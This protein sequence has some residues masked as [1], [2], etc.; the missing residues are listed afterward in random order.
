MRAVLP[1]IVG[2]VDTFANRIHEVLASQARAQQ[3][4]LQQMLD[5][6]RHVGAGRPLVNINASPRHASDLERINLDAPQNAEQEAQLRGSSVAISDFLKQNWEPAWRKAGVRPS[7]CLM[8]FSVL[9]QA[10]KLRALRNAG[11]APDYAG[12][13]GRAAL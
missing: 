8:Q 5:A 3:A 12:Q 13:I 2:V 9:L 4:S 6:M 11:E 1:A 7:A 10:R